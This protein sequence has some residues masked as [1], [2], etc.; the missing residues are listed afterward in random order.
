M[1]ILKNRLFGKRSASVHPVL[2]SRTQRAVHMYPCGQGSY[3][4]G[5]GSHRGCL[6]AWGLNGGRSCG[7]SNPERPLP[8]AVGSL[9]LVVRAFCG[10]TKTM[11]PLNLGSCC[12]PIP[13]SSVLTGVSK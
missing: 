8:S 2:N 10:T 3:A 7:H 5:A 9:A 13:K 1:D 11:R 4:G 6:V 12:L